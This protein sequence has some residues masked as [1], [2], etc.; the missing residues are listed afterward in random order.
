VPD[1]LVPAPLVPDALLLAVQAATPSS[2]ATAA[3]TAITD[4]RFRMAFPSRRAHG[5]EPR[6][7]P[8][9]TYD[10][11]GAHLGELDREKGANLRPAGRRPEARALA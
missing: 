10:A 5:G 11:A 7:P 3:A 6:L 8:S 4:G 2:A 1:A 9:A